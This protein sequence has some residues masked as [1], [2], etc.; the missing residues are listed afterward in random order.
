[1]ANKNKHTIKAIGG[2][3]VRE[4]DV[5]TV[6]DNTDLNNLV[7]SSTLLHPHQSTS[8][9][10]HDG[11][12]EVYMFIHGTG[13]MELDGETFPVKAGDLIVIEDGVFHRVFN[14]DSIDMYFVCVFDGRRT[15]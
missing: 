4:T 3:V 7:L 5:Y 8:G 11:Q 10:K 1:M 9:H 12:E 6:T 2:E 14:S 15:V 13:M